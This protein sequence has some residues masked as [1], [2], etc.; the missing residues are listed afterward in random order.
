ML[1][2]ESAKLPREHLLHNVHC[3]YVYTSLGVTVVT[4]RGLMVRASAVAPY[5]AVALPLLP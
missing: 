5:G 1:A 2:T 4:P 3:I